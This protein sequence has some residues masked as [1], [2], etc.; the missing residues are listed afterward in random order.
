[1]LI[2]WMINLLSH[3]MSCRP[4]F[5]TF[6]CFFFFPCFGFQLHW[7]L[8]TTYIYA[9]GLEEADAAALKQKGL[10]HYIKVS[11]DLKGSIDM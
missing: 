7:N 4:S 11:L 3:P 1:M 9:S 6:L 5:L 2:G 8:A 10:E